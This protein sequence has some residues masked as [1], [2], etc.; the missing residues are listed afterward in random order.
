MAQ[1]LPCPGLACVR[2]LPDRVAVGIHRPRYGG[3]GRIER[4]AGALQ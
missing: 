1:P 2:Q 4:E 3:V